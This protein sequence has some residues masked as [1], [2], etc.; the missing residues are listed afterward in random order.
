MKINNKRLLLISLRDPFL[1]SDRVMPPMGIMSLHAFMLESGFDSTIENNFDLDNLEKYRDFTHFGISC[2]TPQREQADTILHAVKKHYPHSV[3][4]L[5]G[6][7]PNYYLE[8]CRQSGF[9]FIVL[10]DGEL[11][12]QQIMA[13]LPDLPPILNIP[14]SEQ[15]M[16][17]F[18]IPYRDP[19]F[20]TQYN[21]Y[22][23]GIKSTTILTAK[24]CPMACTFCEDARTKVRYF[25]PEHIDRQIVQIKE[26]GYEGVMF[27]DDIFA[28]TVKRIQALSKSIEKHNIYYRCFG[29]AN[30]MTEEMCQLLADSGCIETGFGAESG[31]Q[32]ILDITKKR[33][34]VKMNQ[35]YVNLCNRHGIKVK[36]FL[37]LGLPGENQQTVAETRGFLDFLTSKRFTSRLGK[38]IT[39]DFD[40]TLFFPYKGTA[41]RSALDQGSGEFD[42]YFTKSADDAM[43]V[44]K[45]KDGMSD[46][47]LRTTSLSQH[48]LV[49]IQQEL[50]NEFKPKVIYG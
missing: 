36:A 28:L 27:F 3:V 48:E 46:P 39:N 13:G 41:I 38:E 4:I 21:F 6:P 15:Q 19:A 23:Q 44:Y 18:P 47:V 32:K 8:D 10:N 12:L 33:T 20:L 14:V 16:N 37:M 50:Q 42:L 34:T 24:G 9:D 17:Q 22:F 25:S 2:M 1:D 45:G 29:H 43:G 40:M 11:A 49:T 30:R 7:H 5:G 31:S 26:A 35:D